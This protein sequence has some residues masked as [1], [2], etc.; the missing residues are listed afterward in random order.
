MSGP[1]S[2]A[3]RTVSARIAYF[4]MARY[5]WVLALA[6]VL[7]LAS[8]YR[9]ALTYGSLKSELEELLPRS[10]P[11]VTALTELRQR[12]PGLRFLGVV[13]E[14]DE[15]ARSAE[16]ERFLDQLAERIRHYPPEL[17]RGVRL[18]TS[19]ER[20]FAERY[21]LQLMEPS[22]VKRLRE[23]VEARRDFEVS[24]AMDTDLDDEDGAKPP[25]LPLDELRHKY[26]ARFGAQG[27]EKKSDRFV[28][29]DG[30]D[31]ALLVQTSSQST[32]FEYD[33]KLLKRVQ[34]DV[35][36]MGGPP[37][38]TRLGYAGD[39][40][41]RVE[42]TQGLASDLGLSSAVV[43]LL[44]IGSLL[45]FYRSWSALVALFVPL[46]LGTWAGFAVV[47][48]PPLS[49]RYLNTNTAFLGS[50]VVGNGINTGIMLL[51]RI[52][53][54]LALGKRVKDAIASGVSE[55]WRATL[56]AALAS[57]A[58][59]GSLIFTD[60][61]GFNQFGWIGSF[62]IVLC[63]V[64]TY[65]LMPPLCL[66]LGERLR[67]APTPPGQRAPRRSIAAS[68]AAFTMRHRRGVLAG[69][70][71]LGLVSLAGLA[72]RRDD[73]IE[74]DLSKL[75]RKDSWVSGERYWG[76]RM[77]AATGR[78]LTPSVV[79]AENAEDVP[80][81]E[82]RLRE[83]KEK[84]G[85]GDL[86]AEVRS[87]QQLLPDARFASI[88]EA[89]LLNA[90]ITPKLRRKLN[91]ADR[92]LL[93]QAL[94]EQ[95]LVPLTAADLP[96]AFAAGLRERDGRVGRSVLVFPKVGGG[97][98][99]AER[100]AGFARD[101]RAAAKEAGAIAAGPLLLSSDLAHAMRADGPRVTLL[102]FGCVLVICIA[103]FGVV[104]RQAWA[105]SGLSVVA[106][107]LGV[108][109]MLGGLAWTGAKLNF[110]NFVALPI[111]FG[112]S[113]DYSINMLRRFQSE[114]ESA[115]ER[116]S[117]TSGALALCSAMTVIGWGALLLVENQAL[118]SFGLFAISGELASLLAAVLALPPVLAWLGPKLTSASEA[119][120]S[121]RPD[122][123]PTALG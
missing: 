73:W 34:A 52:Q 55:S 72:T 66:L 89:K 76:K 93:E 32:G 59:Y 81:L 80:K 25:E 6:A 106:L 118:F 39:V 70:A 117:H 121:P 1:D 38:G 78:Y 9:T 68:I 115:D 79:M 92:Q 54:E 35:Q 11:S 101:V 62:G 4:M 102:S 120:R 28:S 107:L 8:G 27:A 95:S 64:A 94:S 19:A 24:R 53:E 77:D 69:L 67:P 85:A 10:A 122:T 87:A 105:F 49:I 46:A 109:F 91:E 20:Q 84:G 74:Y 57:A 15:P 71:V 50:I 43:G 12:L 30:R 82:A 21:A 98:W 56:A 16:A 113:A 26:E 13:I 33:L 108:S 63:W 61:R 22:D 60:F 23:A 111:T 36:A 112:I 83:L 29:P 48:L 123:A 119:R 86:I 2:S 99:Q 75:R 40:A 88:E 42:E 65:W 18:D 3:P 31:L 103:A 114:G 116:L 7:L 37:R 58:S 96:E 5:R 51:A 45:W 97:T 90:A 44:V 100:L 17:V 110:S 14:V 104:G 41:T 47:A